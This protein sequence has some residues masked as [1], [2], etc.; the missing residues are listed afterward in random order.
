MTMTWRPAAMPHDGMRSGSR[1]C[2]RSILARRVLPRRGEA[3]DALG[4]HVGERREVALHG[5][6]FCRF[7][8][9][10]CT[11]APR[12][13]VIRKAMIR[14]GTA[15]RSAGSA[16]SSLMVGRLRDRLRQSLDRIGLDARVRRMRTRHALDPHR[17]SFP[18]RSEEPHV[19]LR[20]T[21]D[22]NPVFA[23]LSRVNN[24]LKRN[25]CLSNA[26]SVT[27]RK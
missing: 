21:A 13:M 12:Q 3:V 8:S 4:E 23:G 1:V 14:V 24:S 15:R 20:I 11:K 6:R 27:I 25:K 7:W 17:I 10:T 18:H 26:K 9:T 22:L 16:I 19:A 2:R 5:A